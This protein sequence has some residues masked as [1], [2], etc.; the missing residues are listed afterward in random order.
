MN[1]LNLILVLFAFL[2]SCNLKQKDVETYALSEIEREDIPITR[3]QELIPPPPPSPLNANQNSEKKIIRNGRMGIEVSDLIQS[4]NKIDTLIK[5]FGAYYAEESFANTNNE[6]TY[7]L[8]IRIPCQI[9]DKF[10]A[11]ISEG[12][13]KIKFKEINSNDVT[14]EFID[15]ETRLVNKRNYLNRY[16]ELLKQAKSVKDI[17]EIEE[18]IRVIEEEIESSMGRLKY[19]S[20]QVE[21]STLYLIITQKK[22]FSFNSDNREKFTEKLKQSL[23]NG[24]FG[25]IDF[26][27]FLIKIWPSWIIIISGIVVWKKFKKTKKVVNKS[28]I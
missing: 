5:N 3:S 9:F 21:F 27:V 24:W 23:S 28:Q 12:T 13:G 22:N 8:T 1:K 4:K 25:F 18:K 2:T 17:I 10:I 15:L 26:V 6:T 7:N 19:L 11:K 16:N 20:N 14:E